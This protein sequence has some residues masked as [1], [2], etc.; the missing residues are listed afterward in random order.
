MTL[1]HLSDT[2]LGYRAYSRSTREGMNQRE[3]DVLE[4]FRAALDA[5]AL[6]EPDLVV[7][8]GDLF[9][10]VRPSNHTITDTFRALQRFQSARGAK[11]L[12]LVGGNHDTP[13]TA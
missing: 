13:R 12:V 11:P 5:I 8:S 3:A 9:H 6:R 4:T 7:H 10:V 1:A 2:H